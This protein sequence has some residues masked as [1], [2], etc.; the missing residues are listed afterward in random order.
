MMR[1]VVAMSQLDV[2]VNIDGLVS[3]RVSL[4]EQR[5]RT[6]DERRVFYRR[7]EERLM[8]LPGM[9]AGIT[10]AGPMRGA[11]ARRLS[12]DGSPAPS[13]PPTVSTVAI[14]TG[15]LEAL[16]V[17]AVRGRLFADAEDS[18]GQS[19]IVN[20]QFAVLHFPG[21]DAVGRSIRLLASAQGQAP[22]GPLTIVGVVPNVRQATA[23]G[24]GVGSQDPVVYLPFAA[25]PLPSATLVARSESGA[26]AV[27]SA[28]R[29]AVAAIDADL[30]VIGGLPLAEALAQERS[31]LTV[32]GSMFGAFA[33]AALGLAMIGLYAVTSYAVTQRT[34]ELGVRLAL[35]ARAGHVWWL[36]T[37]RAALQFAVGTALGLGGAL[38]A[39]QLL[40]GFLFNISGRDPL[41]LIGVSTLML[42]VAVVASA[43]PA[44]R[45]MRTDPVVALRAD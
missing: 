35:G 41:T 20:E 5:Y 27:T 18:S 6:V 10:S 22:D 45:A 16:G 1:N 14:G 29:E 32:F 3:A 4:P 31:I 42:L 24:V 39:G 37:R 2:G 44:W 26:A 15:Y 11:V 34:R 33:T 30:P 9:Q 40:Q 38:G 21:E 8:S 13:E 7:L 19:V 36:V 43:V 17:G 28:L 23:R 25:N 12:I